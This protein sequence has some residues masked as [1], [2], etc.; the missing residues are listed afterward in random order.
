MTIDRVRRDGIAYLGMN[1]EDGQNA[2]E[3]RSIKG[4]VV[5]RHGEDDDEVGPD[6]VRIGEGDDACVL[7]LSSW[8]GAHAFAEQLGV[9]EKCSVDVARV[10]L[11]AAEGS[12][13]ELAGLATIFACGERGEPMP[14]RLVL[15]GHS[16][17]YSIYDGAGRLGGLRLADVQALA[18]AMPRAAAGIEDLMLSACNTGHPTG[19]SQGPG[20]ESWRDVFPNLK[21]AW[22]YGG[23]GDR[24]SPSGAGAVDHIA[25]FRKATAGPAERVDVR[26]ATQGAWLGA[27]VAIWSVRE[28]YVPGR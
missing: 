17:G 23:E 11:R 1:G 12:R 6:H 26:K 13:D 14:G 28:G 4:A 8:E 25:R 19:V 21:V 3:A 27:N 22:G 7:D 10:L 24:K 2:R 20:L 16:T 15:S 18:R 5:V 9:G